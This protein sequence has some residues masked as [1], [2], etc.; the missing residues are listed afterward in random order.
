[1]IQD[2]T[3]VIDSIGLYVEENGEQLLELINLIDKG[4][5]DAITGN[6]GNGDIR[7]VVI[8]QN[9]CFKVQGIKC[10]FTICDENSHLVKVEIYRADNEQ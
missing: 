8:I 5:I 10:W 2:R 4:L 1:M 3:L 6:L 9:Q 7:A